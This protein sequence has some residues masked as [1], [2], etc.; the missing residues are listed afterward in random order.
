MMVICIAVS[1]AELLTSRTP[2]PFDE[3]IGSRAAPAHPLLNLLELSADPRVLLWKPYTLLTYG[4]AH[5]PL[6]GQ[7]NSA[8]HLIFNMIGL[9]FFGNFCETLLGRRTFLWFYLASI[10]FAGAVYFAI[11]ALAG[12]SSSVVGASGALVA[13]LVY[14]AWKLPHQRVFLF[15]VFEAPLWAVAVGY[16]AMDLFGAL[17]RSESNT[18]FTCHL[19]GALFAT[20][21]YQLNW[22]FNWVD[23]ARWAQWRRQAMTRRN[24]RVHSEDSDLEDLAEKA[25]RLLRKI[26]EKGE[27][28]LTKR[29]R[30]LLERYSREVQNKRA[31]R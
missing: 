25:D 28:S 26:S 6:S 27:A 30:E 4:F 16:V 24:L 1:I 8:L 7:G 10:I 12:A 9:Y 3:T 18:A 31:R 21:Y 23:P 13:C 15:G 11:G 22:S 14:V 20:L 2:V 29:E 17:G 19:G 5:A